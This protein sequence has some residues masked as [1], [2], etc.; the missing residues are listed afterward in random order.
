M[1]AEAS[2]L[3]LALVVAIFAVT[4]RSAVVGSAPETGDRMTPNVAAIAADAVLFVKAFFVGSAKRAVTISAGQSRAFNV[5][6]MGEPDVRG[7]TGV[8]KPGRGGL[9]FQI[10]LDESRFSGR[11][12]ELV[13][14]TAG[15][16]LVLRQAGERAIRVEGVA[17]FALS[18]SGFFGV[19]LVQEIDGLRLMRIKYPGKGDP[20]SGQGKGKSKGEDEQVAF[21]K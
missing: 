7:L 11:S 2:H 20:T 5:N 19:G 17:R 15:A 9:R 16:G 4:H 18:G 10:D 1:A 6:G 13:G 3:N 12:A 14:V 21:H 8:N